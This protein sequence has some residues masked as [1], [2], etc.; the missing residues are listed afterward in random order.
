M[1]EAQGRRDAEGMRDDALSIIVSGSSAATGLPGYLI[2]LR[3]ELSLDIRLLLTA[4]AERFLPAQVASWYADEVFTSADDALNPTEFAR[5]SVGVVALPAT[6]NLLA[7]AALGLAATPAQTVL[8]AADRPALF[9]PSMNA[10]MWNKPTTRRYVE[11]LRAEGHTVV[12]P[13]S[14]PV[15]ELWSRDN[16]IGPGMPTPNEAAELIVK[17]L[18]QTMAEA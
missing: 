10:T 15:Y 17:W 8:L 4:S 6:A 13:I 12:D 7:G 1:P 2:W 9:F 14:Q 18:E 5:R 3:Q 11:T 16:T